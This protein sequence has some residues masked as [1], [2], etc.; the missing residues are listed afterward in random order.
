LP[1]EEAQ[2]HIFNSRRLH[3]HYRSIHHSP[4]KKGEGAIDPHNAD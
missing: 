2:N 4:K 1:N 3:R